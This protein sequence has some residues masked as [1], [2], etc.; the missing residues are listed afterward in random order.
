MKY[1]V[2]KVKSKEYPTF[3]HEIDPDNPLLVG[4]IESKDKRLVV[5]GDLG[6]LTTSPIVNLEETDEGYY[7]ETQNSYYELRRIPAAK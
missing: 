7:V 5:I 4:S 6:K 3:M 1:N 2:Y